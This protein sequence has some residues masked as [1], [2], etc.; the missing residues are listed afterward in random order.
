MEFVVDSSDPSLCCLW[1]VF[2]VLRIRWAWLLILW[3]FDFCVASFLGVSQSC[4][5]HPFLED[6]PLPLCEAC[7]TWVLRCFLVVLG[8]SGFTVVWSGA[9]PFNSIHRF[10]INKISL[11][12]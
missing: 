9:F 7:V 5:T 1:H 3:R 8:G 11:F 6:S 2:L 4:T 12:C 10:S